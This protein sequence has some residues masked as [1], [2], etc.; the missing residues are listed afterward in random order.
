MGTS[1]GGIRN[2]LFFDGGD[3]LKYGIS[4]EVSSV[5][6]DRSDYVFLH[7]GNRFSGIDEDEPLRYYLCQEHPA[8]FCG[9]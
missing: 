3:E 9:N 4:G 1:V 5:C 2:S 6:D 8:P 7:G